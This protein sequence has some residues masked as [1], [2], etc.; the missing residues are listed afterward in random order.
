MPKL[1]SLAVV[2]AS[3][4]LPTPSS[5][6]QDVG[7]DVPALTSAA[8][9]IVAADT[10]ATLYF[11]VDLLGLR[12]VSTFRVDEGFGQRS[13]LSDGKPFDVTVLATGEG[14]DALQL[15]IVH[16]AG[17]PKADQPGPIQERVGVRYLT[18]YFSSIDEIL[19]RLVSAGV[20][21]LGETPFELG[22]GRRFAVVH[23]PNGVTVELIG[24]AE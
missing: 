9:A 3:S 21:T 18:F 14:A 6:G 22:D 5:Y 15:K 4:L 13:G 20:S 8:A 1:I 12:R 2:L 16:F 7:A 19:E 10:S 11:Y 24:A 23:D 17:A